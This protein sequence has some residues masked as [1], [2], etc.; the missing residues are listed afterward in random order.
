MPPILGRAAAH[1]PAE[2]CVNDLWRAPESKISI[3]AQVNNLSRGHGDVR[4]NVSSS[5]A[6][7]SLEDPSSSLS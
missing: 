1:G 5:R 3:Y 2:G 4:M 7:D 6:Q